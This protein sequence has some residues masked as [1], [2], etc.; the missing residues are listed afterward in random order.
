VQ[1]QIGGADQF[2]NIMAGAE[3]I[4]AMRKIESVHF[5]DDASFQGHVGSKITSSLS[6]SPKDGNLNEPL[7]L[8]VPLL[9]T[10]AGV[11]FGK[12]RVTQS[13]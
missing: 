11:K 3:A 6:K 7:G 10:S 12:V 9:T 1:V 2:G 5:E 8:T 13:D 4:K